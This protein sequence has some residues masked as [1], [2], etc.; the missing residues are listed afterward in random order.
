[1]YGIRALKSCRARH[2]NLRQRERQTVVIR[3]GREARRGEGP[4]ATVIRS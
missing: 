2:N 3:R 4:P 1:M